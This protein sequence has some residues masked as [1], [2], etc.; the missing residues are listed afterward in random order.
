MKICHESLSLKT[1]RQS[2][3]DISCMTAAEQ[4][5][6]RNSDMMYV[7]SC[8]RDMDVTDTEQKP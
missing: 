2:K 3:A 7:T 4:T 8:N 6:H 1:K 5:R